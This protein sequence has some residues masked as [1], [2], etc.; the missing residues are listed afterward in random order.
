MMKKQWTT[1]FLILI[2]LIVVL[3]AVL[4][5]DPIAINFGF[6]II[7]MPL[8]VILI[9]TLL[10]GVLMAVLLST[11]IILNYKSEEKKLR[12]EIEAV[13]AQKEE[14]KEKLI[15]SHQQEVENLLQETEHSKQEIRQLN[16]RISNMDASANTNTQIEE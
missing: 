3:F 13:E 5:V 6:T 9:V 10:I 2:A 14:E 15:Q 11:G 12:K 4:N 16:R 7:E 8:A 1:V